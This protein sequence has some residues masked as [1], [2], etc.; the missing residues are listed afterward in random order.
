MLWL[1]STYPTDQ[2]GQPGADRGDCP[3]TSGVPSD[4]E[5][6]LANAQGKFTSSRD[7]RTLGLM[8]Q[9]SHLLEYQIWSYWVDLLRRNG[10]GLSYG[11]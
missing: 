2:A 8:P 4:V 11:A 3:T 1:D 6:S 10:L 5:S 7:P 9:Y